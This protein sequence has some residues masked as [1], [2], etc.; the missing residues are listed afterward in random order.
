MINVKE[1][2]DF[3]E[4]FLEEFD[5]EHSIDKNL[6]YH[7]KLE[8]FLANKLGKEIKFT[9]N[10]QTAN[11]FGVS[12]IRPKSKI[13]TTFL[14]YAI[15]HGNE[16]YGRIEPKKSLQNNSF[17]KYKENIKIIKKSTSYNNAVVFLY[18]ISSTNKISDTEPERLKYYFFDLESKQIIK[19][20]SEEFHNLHIEG[21][22]FKLSKEKLQEASNI[23]SDHVN[24]ELSLIYEQYENINSEHLK[25]RK[26][27]FDKRYNDYKKTLESNEK[28]L[29][30][31]I[32]ELDRKILNARSFDTRRNYQAG[33]NKKQDELEKLKI[34]HNKILKKHYEKLDRELTLE[35]KNYEFEVNVN[36][37][38]IICLEYPIEKLEITNS[39]ESKLEI[40]NNLILNNS[41]QFKCPTCSKIAKEFRL[42]IE[43]HFCCENCSK[44]FKKYYVCKKD[45]VVESVMTG[46]TLLPIKE[47]QCE[48]CKE[49]IEPEHMVKS[50]EGKNICI[51]KQQCDLTGQFA[52]KEDLIH[53]EHNNLNVLKTEADK[54]NYSN[55]YFLKSDL[56]IAT[57]E[58]KLIASK[59]LNECKKTKLKFNPE[60]F[61]EKYSN[62]YENLKEITYD[63]IKIP[64]IKELVPKGKCKMSENTSYIL[65]S[66]FK[67]FKEN[68]VLYD[69][70]TKKVGKI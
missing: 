57:G 60:N 2:K 40:N 38:S 28:K 8:D 15:K 53:L 31:K 69:K 65:V 43:D 7:V 27:D 13:L 48:Y 62:L 68:L 24:K 67:F 14:T 46:E 61:G 55:K 66:Y 35:I 56:E 25:D 39:H 29:E 4:L 10:R 9:F 58:K 45:N 32:S 50:F 70:E 11:D 21:H 20:L 1:I 41:I 30:R 34:Q 64:E 59:Y 16:S 17:D 26:K 6:I 3:V 19:S 33:L 23:V 5:I 52:S 47:N 49:Y 36:L 12:H 51:C 44:P 37:Q 42:S 63:L 22:T 54:C 18:K